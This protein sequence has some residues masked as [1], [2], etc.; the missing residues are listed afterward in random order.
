MNCQIA[1]D[2]VTCD[3]NPCENEA[4][5]TDATDAGY[6]CNCPEGFTG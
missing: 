1:G 5:C 3:D 2:A 6:E 4:A